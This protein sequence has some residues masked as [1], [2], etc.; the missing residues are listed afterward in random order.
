[1][2]TGQRWHPATIFVFSLVMPC[3]LAVAAAQT[4]NSPQ[5]P[6]VD[7]GFRI[8]GTV[9]NGVGGSPLAR[10]RVIIY[11]VNNSQNAHWMITSED[12]RFEFKELGRGKFNLQGAKRGFI[13]AS[14]DQHEQYSTAIVTGAALDTENLVLRLAPVAVLSGKVLDELGDPVRRATVSLYMEDRRVGVGRIQQVRDDNTDDQG[15]YEFTPLQAGIY[16]VSVSAAPWYAVH[17]VGSGQQSS[18]EPPAEVDQS[19]DV[20]YPITY[21]KDATEPDEASPILIRGGDRVEADIHLS[22][23]PA[24]HLL[25]RVPGSLERGFNIP[26]LRKPAFDGMEDVQVNGG[27][28]VSP[29]VFELSGVAA[30]RY[31]VR[32]PLSPPGEDTQWSEVEMDLSANDEELDV[33]KGKPSST[34]KCTLKVL[35][36]ETLPRELGVLLRNSKLRVVAWQRVNSKGEVE[37]QDVEPGKYEVLVQAVGMAY[38][39]LR[40][41]ANGSETPGHMVSVAAG[42]S[43]TVTLSLVGG[44]TN[45]EGF[46]KQ[47]ARAVA[48]AMVVLVPTDP[49]SNREMFRRD[50]SDQDGSFS[51]RGVIPGAYTVCAIENGWDLDWSKTAVIGHYCEHGRPVVVGDRA[52][53]SMHLADTVEVQPR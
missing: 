8:A 33:S 14:Y 18:E 6:P 17:A 12:G 29:G 34:V 15:S 42:Q 9:V 30:G 36:G 31:T 51:L 16:F 3:L 23:V 7:G 2:L 45:V 52:I 48:G 19:L 28:M 25:F 53:G 10:A 11:D 27:Q 32:T 22:P 46:V 47:N 4:A 41:S 24:L 35:G 1:M 21:Y 49:E 20:A 37:F 43:L 38:S 40:I 5:A 13:T 44:A 50:Q 39:V 26:T